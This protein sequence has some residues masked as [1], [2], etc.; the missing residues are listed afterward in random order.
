MKIKL[1]S[2]LLFIPLLGISQISL[3][4]DF[5]GTTSSNPGNGKPENCFVH[6]NLLYFNAYEADGYPRMY[7]TDGTDAGTNALINDGATGLI[8]EM[9]TW[10]IAEYESNSLL[11][12]SYYE[13]A[14]N[15]PGPYNRVYFQNGQ[16]YAAL[17]YFETAPLPS[18]KEGQLIYVNLPA[19]NS[20]LPS[21][22]YFIVDNNLVRIAPGGSTALPTGNI[23]SGWTSM[24]EIFKFNDNIYFVGDEGLGNGVELYLHDV[25]N[26]T[27]SQVGNSNINPS[28]DSNPT[29]F[30][31]VNGKM[32]FI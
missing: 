12:L 30:L 6:N 1:L 29:D 3:I 4:K 24:S 16:Y 26:N 22:L 17:I 2:A 28:G 32:Y 19:I 20:S 25:I 18:A 31:I 21:L 5:S 27:I 23:T 9:P 10:T 11:F 13:N 15:L 14:S 8:S 7:R